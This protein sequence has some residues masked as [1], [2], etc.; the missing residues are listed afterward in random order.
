MVDSMMH[1]FF[2]FEKAACDA[3]I[4]LLAKQLRKRWANRLAGILQ[5]EEA[6]GPRFPE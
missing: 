1:S 4:S 6:Y 3:V 2:W 5:A